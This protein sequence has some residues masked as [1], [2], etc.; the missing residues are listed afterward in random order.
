MG[1]QRF[2]AEH[3]IRRGVD[4]RRVYKRRC[5]ASDNL[6]LVLGCENDLTHTRLGLSV[7]RKVGNAVVRNRWKRLIRE[8]FRISG[9]RLPKG[10]DLVII[11]R[12]GATPSLTAA[13]ESL[14][15]LASRVEHKLRTK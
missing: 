6:L 10:V 14:P 8:S 1:D 7:S 5:A 13:L 2:L 12:P 9:R 3:H 15:R 4:F 11:P